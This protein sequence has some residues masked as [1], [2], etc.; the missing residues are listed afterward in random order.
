MAR[1]RRL[2]EE[3][4][5]FGTMSNAELEQACRPELS[6]LSKDPQEAL[7]ETLGLMLWAI[8]TF[9]KLGGQVNPRFAWRCKK[10]AAHIDAGL[11]E[12]FRP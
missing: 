4:E 11:D 10:M 5:P 6:S 1:R 2:V 3:Q 12:Y 8:G 7:A 9:R